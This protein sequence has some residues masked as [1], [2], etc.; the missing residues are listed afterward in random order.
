MFHLVLA[1]GHNESLAALGC[2]ISLASSKGHPDTSNYPYG[3][4]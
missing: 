4:A 2:K 1:I 3:P